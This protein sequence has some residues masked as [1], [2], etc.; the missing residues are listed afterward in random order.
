M[1]VISLFEDISS[2]QSDATPADR[3]IGTVMAEIDQMAHAT[4][5]SITIAT[6]LRLVEK[7]GGA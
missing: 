3:A 5:A 1:D 4:F 6:M 7:E 2:P